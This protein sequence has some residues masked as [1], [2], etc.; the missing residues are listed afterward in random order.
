MDWSARSWFAAFFVALVLGLGGCGGPSWPQVRAQGDHQFM[1]RQRGVVTVD[2]LPLDVQLWTHPGSRTPPDELGQQFHAL[3]S[4][5]L[6]AEL[7]RRGYQVAAQMDWNGSYVQPEGAPAQA[8]AAEAIDLTTYSLS[9]YGRAV[10]AVKSTLPVPYLPHRLGVATGADATLYVG[11]WAYVGDDKRESTGTKVV[12]G[13][14]IGILLVAVVAVV[15]IAARKGGGGGGAASGAGRA[16]ASAGRAAARVAVTAGRVA[17]RVTAP[18]MRSVAR[19]GPHLVR[20]FLRTADAFGRAGGGTHVEIYAGRPEYFE[21]PTA[22]RAGRS[23]MRMEMTLI[24]NRTGLV[25]WH[26]GQTFPANATWSE[27]MH[28]V[29]SRLMATLPAS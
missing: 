27:H 7:A 8:M 18:V 10:A 4:G 19:S 22:P 13:V 16:A 1:T 23:Q 24:D 3:A 6:T 12:K 15:I 28:Q 21:E 11:G 14:A 25:L 2:I 29:M 9:G 20:G 17:G 5:A 26:T